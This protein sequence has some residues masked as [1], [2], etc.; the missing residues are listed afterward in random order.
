VWF[1][2]GLFYGVMAVNGRSLVCT[3]LAVLTAN[4]GLWVALHQLHVGFLQHPQ[5]WLI[6]AALAALAAEYLD[7]DR[8]TEAQS[9]AARYLALSVVYIS[10][11]AD[12]YIA[13]VGN[14]WRLPL[15][16]M[17]LSVAGVLAG[18]MLRVRSF[19]YLG[20]A[21]LS[22]DIVS[23]IWYAAVNRQ[24][25]WIWY[26]CGIALGAAIIALFAV[27]EKRRN[28]VLAAVERLKTWKA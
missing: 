16:L 18:I 4:V 9:R 22:L 25:T 14:D 6:P 27:F 10:S 7:R 1:V 8:L 2:F 15:I 12:M 11:S 28:D 3:V 26:A 17:G 23:M 20:V 24:Q 21:F 19:L 5:L 13:G